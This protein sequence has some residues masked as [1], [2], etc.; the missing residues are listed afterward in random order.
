[1]TE[2]TCIEAVAAVTTGT[3]P[4]GAKFAEFGGWSMPLEYAGAGV[5]AE[6]AAVRT[7]VGLFDVSHLG[8]VGVTG[9]G[10]GR[11]REP[12]PDQRPAPR[13]RPARRSTP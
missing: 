13:S 3:W 11:V 12:L 6:H 4:L 1:M 2:S 10:S 8:K 9:S 7:A 5:L